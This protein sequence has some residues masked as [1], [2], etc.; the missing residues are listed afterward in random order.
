MADPCKHGHE[1]LR[2]I[3][4]FDLDN[5]CEIDL[6]LKLV[7]FKPL[8]ITTSS[9]FWERGPFQLFIVLCAPEYYTFMQDTKV[10]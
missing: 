6:D 5:F 7:N 2:F 3:N 9:K 10:L 8:N 1:N 4:L